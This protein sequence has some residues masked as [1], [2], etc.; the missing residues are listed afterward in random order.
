[1]QTR[2]YLPE[3][4]THRHR[5]TD[6]Q[7][8]TQTHTE[9]HTQ[10]HT[11]TH[12]DTHRHRQ[13]HTDTHTETQTH[14]QTQTDTHTHTDTQTQTQTH[15]HTETERELL[16]RGRALEIHK[17]GN[18]RAE[19]CREAE[20]HHTKHSTGGLDPWHRKAETEMSSGR[21]TVR[22]LWREDTGSPNHRQIHTSPESQI[23]L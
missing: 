23:Q 20:G 21:Y 19:R 22:W 14:T 18:R 13:T 7:K 11:D 6:T 2:S 12:R 8:H 15:T 17:R 4:Q 9:T 10:T 5:H 1:M 16:K 3:T